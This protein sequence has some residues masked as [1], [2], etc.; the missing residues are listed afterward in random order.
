MRSRDAE[1]DISSKVDTDEALACLLQELIDIQV[2]FWDP[3][4]RDHECMQFP[5]EGRK[6]VQTFNALSRS[7]IHARL[8]HILT[9]CTQAILS[10]AIQ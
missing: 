6:F 10:G 1:S 9:W 5:A 8:F 4:G 3:A 2:R 7:C